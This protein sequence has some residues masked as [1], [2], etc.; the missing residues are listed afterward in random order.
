MS[1][2]PNIKL[3]RTHTMNSLTHEEQK[4]VLIVYV[5]PEPRSLNGHL[6]DIAVKVLSE[7]GYKVSVSDLYSE[8]FKPLFDRSDY[9]FYT[10]TTFNP[11]SANM[12]S[13]QLDLLPEDVRREKQRLEEADLIIFQFPVWRFTC[14]SMLHAYFERVLLPGWAYSTDTPALKG[15]KALICT[16]AGR[17]EFDY[18]H[19]KSGTMK[20]NFRHI[21]V[22]TLGYVGF[23]VLE[24]FI[25][26]NIFGLSDKD[27]DKKINQFEEV[28]RHIETRPLLEI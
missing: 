19:G 17:V 28:M 22:G 10:E 21:L 27:R 2:K 25:I 20:E 12:M 3:D 6:K 11:S 7:K 15:K 26:Y 14:P 9:P 13:S 5:H 16:T 4:K 18:V 1:K 24:P 23:E 8:K